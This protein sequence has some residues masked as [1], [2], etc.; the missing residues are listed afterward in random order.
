MKMLE[1]LIDTRKPGTIVLASGDAAEAEYSAG[2]FKNVER[3]LSNGW[4]VELVAWN[5]GLSQEYRNPT[6][7][8]RWEG[9]FKILLLDGFSEELLALYA[10]P[11][12]ISH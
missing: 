2:F 7:L 8:K 11:V 12:V 6:F 5:A 1:S 9:R 3:A 4:N 10:V